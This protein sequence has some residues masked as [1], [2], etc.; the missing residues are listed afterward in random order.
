MTTS[1]P[2]KPKKKSLFGLG[3]FIGGILFDLYGRY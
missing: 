1:N 2:A 3:E